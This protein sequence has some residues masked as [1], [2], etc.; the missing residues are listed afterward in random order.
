MKKIITAL[1]LAV[2]MT[3]AALSASAQETFTDVPEGSWYHDAVYYCVEN[4]LFA[5]MTDTTFAPNNGMTR[6]MFVTVLASQHEFNRDDYK[7]SSFTDVPAG[8]WYSVNVE[9][10]YKEGLVAGVGGGNFAPDKVITRAQLVTLI[11]TYAEYLGYDMSAGED[12]DLSSFKDAKDVPAWAQDG[13]KW[14]IAND[15]VGGVKSADDTLLA[16]NATATRA[17]VALIMMKLCELPV[18]EIVDP[19]EAK[20][21]I[22]GNDISLYK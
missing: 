21:T 18:E 8:K 20:M 6:A 2:I 13:F 11:R 1:V 16:P 19:G 22:N 9:W 4:K 5:G 15:V 17:T 10:A 14:A 3:A 12:V 7:T